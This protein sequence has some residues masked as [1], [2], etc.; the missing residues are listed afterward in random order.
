M[1]D[2]PSVETIQ[3]F[4]DELLCAFRFQKCQEVW[5]KTQVCLQ[6]DAVICMLARL[7]LTSVLIMV[8]V[9]MALLKKK[10]RG[11]IYHYYTET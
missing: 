8:Y 6:M 4:A 7:C 9:I 3:T 11:R 1:G 10:I 2:S 5:V